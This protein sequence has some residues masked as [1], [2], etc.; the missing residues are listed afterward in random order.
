MTLGSQANSYLDR[1][2]LPGIPHRY[3]VATIDSGNRMSRPVSSAA[4]VPAARS[5]TNGPQP[6]AS[7]F[8]AV[9]TMGEMRAGGR[10]IVVRL[11]GGGEGGL[12]VE[13]QTQIGG[14][15]S[16]NVLIPRTG[17]NELRDIIPVSPEGDQTVWYTVTRMTF[18]GALGRPI[19]SNKIII[20]RLNLT[21]S[22]PVGSPITAPSPPGVLVTFAA[23]AN[24]RVGESLRLAT[25]AGAEC[26]SLN[27]GIATVTT[28][29]NVSGVAPGEA[30]I[31]AVT[32]GAN[33][34]VLM[35]AVRVT[36]SP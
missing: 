29:G 5:D 19:D 31:I 16:R 9:A 3:Q 15:V 1:D 14:G 32:R 12:R 24:V 20:P 2:V 7:P 22:D 27:P 33:G 35:S 11:G 8:S 23:P 21:T 34:T 6:G 13:R 18:M 28:D 17:S 25:A 10:E 4:I 30:Q 36:V 26:V